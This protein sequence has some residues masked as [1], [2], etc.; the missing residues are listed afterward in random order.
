MKIR[1]AKDVQ[2]LDEKIKTELGIDVQEYKNEEVVENVTELLLFPTYIVSWV[3]RP[4]LLAFFCYCFGFYAL[5]LVHIEYVIYAIF[6]LVLF[7]ICGV[8]LGVLLFLFKMKFDVL[9]IVNYS[10]D[11]LKQAIED[12][13]KVNHQITEENKKD[14]LSLLFKGIVHIVTIPMLSTIISSKIP[15]MGSVFARLIKRILTFFSDKLAFEEQE[16]V[17]YSDSNHTNSNAV[18]SY[19]GT[20]N[21]A[22]EGLETVANVVFKITRFPILF[23]CVVFLL[24][25]TVFIYFIN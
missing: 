5:N 6:G 1:T 20:I 12:L 3:V 23:L 4:V 22:S 17:D 19:L 8:L 21:S 9:A 14:V 11:I 24:L 10:L 2:L 13:S 25:I 16:I 7:I 15:V 18:V